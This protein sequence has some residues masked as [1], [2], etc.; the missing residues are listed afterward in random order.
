MKPQLIQKEVISTLSFKGEILM[1]QDPDI[2]Q[3]IDLAVR[4][5][6]AYHSKVSIVFMDD[7]GLKRVDTTIWAHGEK[8]ICLK[9]GTW[10]PI[11]RILE[12][13]F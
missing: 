10:L 1:T 11:S 13:K 12:V 8:Y 2:N 7:E 4:L 5:G 6:N 9:G 3:Q